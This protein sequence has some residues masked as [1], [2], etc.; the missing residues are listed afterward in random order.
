M[1]CKFITRLGTLAAFVIACSS[2]AGGQP[3][4]PE[5]STAVGTPGI[6]QGYIGALQVFDDGGGEMLYAGGSFSSIAGRSGTPLIARW[7]RVG[8]SW[9][10]VGGGLNRGSTN[11]FIT[12]IVPFDAGGGPKLV[13]GGFFR[14]AFGIPVSGVGRAIAASNRRTEYLGDI[15]EHDRRYFVSLTGRF[16]SISALRELPIGAS[17]RVLLRDVAEVNFGRKDADTRIGIQQ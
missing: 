11:G 13:V 10:S 6:S 3:C 16:T 8:Q 4:E 2:L 9:S 12:S 17:R 5:W 7:D 14:E 1:P 15:V